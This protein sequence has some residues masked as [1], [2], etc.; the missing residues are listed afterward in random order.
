MLTNII[1]TSFYFRVS[2][3]F[4]YDFCCTK[5]DSGINYSVLAASQKLKPHPL[6][7]VVLGIMKSYS[8]KRALIYYIPL[9]ISSTWLKSYNQ[10]SK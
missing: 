1:F 4:P 7:C 8:F 6:V 10:N 2:V 3:T 9:T 5:N